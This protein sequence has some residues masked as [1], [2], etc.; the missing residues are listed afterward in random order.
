MIV[1]RF[2]FQKLK[3]RMKFL[4]FQVACGNIYFRVMKIT[5]Y[6]IWSRLGCGQSKRVLPSRGGSAPRIWES[7]LTDWPTVRKPRRD[8]L[9][10]ELKYKSPAG[11]FLKISNHKINVSLRKIAFLVSKTQKIPP[12]AGHFLVRLFS[13]RPAMWWWFRWSRIILDN[14]HILV[15]SCKKPTMRIILDNHHISPHTKIKNMFSTP[16]PRFS[17]FEC[18][19][20]ISILEGFGS[21]R[22]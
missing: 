17:D 21:L 3:T 9:R 5:C 13:G 15:K 10:Y 20:F 8:F 11:D 1:L 6:G 7:R 2:V 22:E 4:W 14:H 18:V 19:F 12:V 16:W